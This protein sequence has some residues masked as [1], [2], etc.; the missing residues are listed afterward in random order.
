M[1]V[2]MSVNMEIKISNTYST[3][4]STTRAQKIHVCTPKVYNI[5]K[6]STSA[7]TTAFT[8]TSA[9]RYQKGMD[10]KKGWSWYKIPSFYNNKQR[11]QKGHRG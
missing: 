10:T 3:V 8:S 5:I 6:S 11:L 1:H 2:P 7:V 9:C 4:S